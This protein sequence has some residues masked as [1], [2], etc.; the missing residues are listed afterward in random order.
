MGL[1]TRLFHIAEGIQIP[2]VHPLNA[3][4]LPSPRLGR[5]LTDLRLHSEL[6]DECSQVRPRPLL[7]AVW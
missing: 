6:W 7:H 5:L 3:Y 4:I 1:F 2:A